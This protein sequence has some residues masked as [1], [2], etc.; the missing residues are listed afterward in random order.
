LRTTLTLQITEFLVAATTSTANIKEWR[1][2]YSRMLSA[3]SAV[4]QQATKGEHLLVQVA[5]PGIQTEDFGILLLDSNSDRLYTRFR[6]DCETWAGNE[7]DWVE[8]LGEEI[9]ERSQELGGRKCLEWMEST[10]SHTVR[11]SDRVGVFVDNYDQTIQQLYVKCIRANVL[12]YRTHLPQFTLEAAAG[13]FGKQMQVEP[14]GWVEVWPNMILTNDMFVTHVK[15]Y[16]MEPEIPDGSLCAI[17]GNLAGSPHGKVVLVDHYGETGGNRYTIKRY[18]VSMNAD[19]HMEGDAAWLHERF[20]LESLNPD[21]KSWDVA[22]AGTV[23]VLG[24]FL[25]VV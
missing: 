20:T 1:G 2:L 6:R 11:V 3:Q 15:G 14:E 23:R 8:G 7:V 10:L 4:K 12:P 24:E 21:Y 18:R 13:K 16:S 19:P 9:F 25:F 5:L 22:S 17:T